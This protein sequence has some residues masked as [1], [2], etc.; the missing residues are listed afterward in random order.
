MEETQPT[1]PSVSYTS[2][3]MSPLHE[4]IN[5]SDKENPSRYN[6]N[7]L[8]EELDNIDLDRDFSISTENSEIG[9]VQELNL[10][11]NLNVCLSS[12]TDKNDEENGELDEEL[13]RVYSCT[14]CPKKFYNSQA[15]GG[16]QNAHKRQRAT[17]QRDRLLRK[18]AAAAT[19]GYMHHYHPYNHHRYEFSSMGYSPLQGSFTSN[20]NRLF[21]V[22]DHS[23]MNKPS[24]SSCLIPSSSFRPHHQLD[25]Q[26]HPGWTASQQPT[27]VDRQPTITGRLM[28]SLP[29]SIPCFP[30]FHKEGIGGSFLLQG[31]CGG[32]GSGGDSR[33]SP[34]SNQE[35]SEK[36]DLALRLSV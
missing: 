34:S 11:E 30:R 3:S 4:M 6:R 7:Q 15:L 28:S 1:E 35:D 32:G 22:Q 10:I 27:I 9:L 21:G 13:P 25:R 5:S 24:S 17:A 33:T 2:S 16:H 14:Y 20:Y 31:G 19:F 18:A 23:M 8:V 12:S 29:R 36:I 26:H